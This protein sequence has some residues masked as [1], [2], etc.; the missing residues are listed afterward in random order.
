ML[1]CTE[2]SIVLDERTEDRCIVQVG[3]VPPGICAEY[4]P[5][6][7]PGYTLEWWTAPP[8]GCPAFACDPSF[9]VR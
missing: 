1:R 7:A 8:S 2:N 3:C 5:V 4:L 9:V 6:C